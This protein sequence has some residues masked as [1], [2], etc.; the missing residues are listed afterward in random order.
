MDLSLALQFIKPDLLVVVVACYV[1][2]MILKTSL[3]KDWLI[4]YVLLIF[5]IVTTICYM[6]VVLGAGFTGKVF[7]EGFIQGLFATALSVYGNQLI[8][9][10]VQRQ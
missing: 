5:A 7:V 3:M 6:A 8:K 9:Q 4:P 2:G 10:F 1:F